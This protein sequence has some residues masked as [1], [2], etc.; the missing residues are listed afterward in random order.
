MVPGVCCLT[1][2]TTCGVECGPCVQYR[3][4]E[5]V[6]DTGHAARGWRGG[7]GGGE[8]PP[9]PVPAGRSLQEGAR[10]LQPAG[11]VTCDVRGEQ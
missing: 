6:T 11:N 4:S 8:G 2:L 9:D 1:Q 7:A 10:C 5:I 3:I